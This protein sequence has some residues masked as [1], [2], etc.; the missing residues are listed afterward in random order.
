MKDSAAGATAGWVG[1]GL[2]V[3]VKVGVGLSGMAAAGVSGPCAPVGANHEQFARATPQSVHIVVEDLGHADMLQG[4]ARTLGRR[5]CGGGTDPD[6]AR[7]VCTG[8]LADFMAGD[9]PDVGEHPGFRR[10]R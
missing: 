10:V 9:V 4:R 3:A 7:G 2:A 5:L 8:L 6:A 1:L